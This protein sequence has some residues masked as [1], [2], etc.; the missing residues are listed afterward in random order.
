[1]KT[2]KIGLVC[3]KVNGAY[4]G[5]VFYFSRKSK[6]KKDSRIVMPSAKQID[7][8]KK[9]FSRNTPPSQLIEC[10]YLEKNIK[11]IVCLSGERVVGKASAPR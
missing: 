5:P 8:L 1:M 3:S 7:Q 11:S 4:K 6:S 10:F 9:F 2:L